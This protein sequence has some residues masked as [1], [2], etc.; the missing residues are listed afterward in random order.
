MFL[1]AFRLSEVVRD[2]DSGVARRGLVKRDT[3][4]RVRLGRASAD[5]VD[6]R[7]LTVV[8]DVEHREIESELAIGPRRTVF[9]RARHDVGPRIVTRV[10][11]RRRLT[12]APVIVRA[13]A[14]VR[15]RLTRT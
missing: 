5:R 11:R 8:E 3:V 4:A 12:L 13:I 6:L 15:I 7:F 10:T 14:E 9:D 1:N 2:T